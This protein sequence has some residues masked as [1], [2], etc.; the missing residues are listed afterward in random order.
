MCQMPANGVEQRRF[1]HA[2][3]SHDRDQTARRDMQRQRLEKR[4]AMGR[5]DGERVKIKTHVAE[6]PERAR[7]LRCK[8]A[9]ITNAAR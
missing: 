1:T 9:G 4:S 6:A 8:I 7:R 2:R 5:L 3:R